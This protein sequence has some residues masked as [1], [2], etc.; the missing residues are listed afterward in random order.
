[1]ERSIRFYVDVF[2]A[3]Q[4]TRPFVIEGDFA[5][6]V[7]EGPSGVRFLLCHLR[8]TNGQML[9]LFQFVE[10]VHPSD[11]VH[12]SRGNTLHVCLVV[13][14]VDAT[15]ARLT[16]SGGSIVFPLIEWGEHRLCYT[17]DPDGNVIEISDAPLEELLVGTLELFPAA[18]LDG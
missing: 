10:P 13:D 7:M 9:E 12:S 4:M 6:S 18:R 11:P 15:V 16:A 1:M 5:E 3:E 2:G 14:D 8:F 17:K